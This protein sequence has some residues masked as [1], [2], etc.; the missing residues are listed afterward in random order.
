MGRTDFQLQNTLNWGKKIEEEA[1]KLN[2]EM[3]DANQTPKQI[4]SAISK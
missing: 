2:I 4:F 3:I 1:K